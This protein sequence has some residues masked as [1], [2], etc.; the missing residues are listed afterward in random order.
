MYNYKAS[1]VGKSTVTVN[2]TIPKADIVKAHGEAFERLKNSLTVEGFRKGKAPVDIAKKHI[3]AEAIYQEMIKSILPSIYEEIVKKESLKPILSPKIELVKAKEGE[4]WELKITVAEKPEIDLGDYKA[5][6]KELKSKSK[7]DE[8]WVPGKEQSS[9]SNKK[10]DTQKSK[11]L[12]DVLEVVLHAA[13]IELPDLV[14]EEEV[15]NRLSRLVDDVQKIGL[16]TEQYLK[17]KNL[18]MD[19]LKTQYKKEISDTY[20]LEFIL[21]EIADKEGIKVEQAD[22]D[23]LFDNIKD[24]KAKEQAKANSYYYATILR[25]QKTLDFLISL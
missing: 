18:T 25:K 10:S 6:I 1:K 17:S 13:Q 2:L 15:N 14:V 3:S 7:K 24:E 22:L 8:I 5:K 23:K 11:Y 19:M 21:S 12:N 16:T 4:D 9:D 20:K